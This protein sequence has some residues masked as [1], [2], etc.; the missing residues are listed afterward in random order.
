MK[1]RRLG[2]TNLQ[3]SLLGLGGFHLVEVPFKE[4]VALINYYLDKGGNYLEVAEL[5]GHGDSEK[6]VGEVMK[7]RRQEC[8]LAT[9]SRNR[10]KKGI[11]ASINQSLKN[12][13]TDWVDIF[14]IHEL[15]RPEVL[16]EIAAPGGALEGI[17][18]AKKEGKIRFVAFS[19]HATPCVALEALGI[20]PF[21]AFMIPLNYF[22]YFNFPQWEDELLSEAQKRD[23][24][25]IAM[26]PLADGF[27]WKSYE[28]ALRFTLTLP[29]GCVVTGANTRDYLEDDLKIANGFV[30]LSQKEREELFRD[31][32]E[33]GNYVCRQC[34]DCLPC[35]EGID[36][37]HVFLL[38]GQ[39]DRQMKDGVVR[40][41][42]EYA[43]RDRL[44][45]WYG[46]QEY[47]QKD[48]QNLKVKATACT[49]CDLCEPKCSYG[50]PII[51]K[52]KIAHQKLVS[53]RPATYMRID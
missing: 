32:P 50:L 25:V 17:E 28:K 46:N 18:K 35:P 9:K 26:K 6:K 20:Y 22:D 15:N 31:A 45:F 43:L 14:F 13:N 2:R 11:L 7:T 34:G 8:I 23:M 4:A 51:N 5:Y 48:Y 19:N 21:D 41:P 49:E 36:I 27:L 29:V 12:L 10:T 1:T 24:G 16:Q 44:R 30:P 37:P 52:L 38:E 39:F 3:L 47:A 33:L 40:D 53:S 42:A